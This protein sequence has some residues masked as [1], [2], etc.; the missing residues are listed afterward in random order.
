MRKIILIILLMTGI[1]SLSKGQSYGL[2]KWKIIY[3][4]DHPVKVKQTNIDIIGEKL[5]PY[6]QEF[7][8]QL[9]K[10]YGHQFDNCYRDVS[11]VGKG[12]N[13]ISVYLIPDHLDTKEN[14][15]K[16]KYDSKGE[17]VYQI[18]Y[19][20]KTKTFSE[21]VFLPPLPR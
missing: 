18:S 11:F 9:T 19:F 8:K 4:K 14:W 6:L 1:F 13:R 3:I 10:K 2:P 7:E 12:L 20:I 5:V 17:S 15:L 16:I 21:I